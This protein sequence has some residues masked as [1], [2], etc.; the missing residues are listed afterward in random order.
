MAWVLVQLKKITETF[1]GRQTRA[2]SDV[3]SPASGLHDESRKWR[4]T[5][6]DQVG[7]VSPMSVKV[8][9]GANTGAAPSGFWG[10]DAVAVRTLR[11]G[12]VDAIKLHEYKPRDREGTSLESP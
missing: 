10:D 6:E 1:T 5:F 3:L 9:G 11:D 2:R 7:N 4:V 8:Q 12:T